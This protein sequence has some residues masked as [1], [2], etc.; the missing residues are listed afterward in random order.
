MSDWEMIRLGDLCQKV[1]TGGTPPTKN[2]AYYKGGVIPWLKTK[3]VN[4][5]GYMRQKPI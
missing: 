4:S 5:V 3:E 1:L 2:T